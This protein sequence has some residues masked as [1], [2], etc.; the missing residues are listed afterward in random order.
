MV[1]RVMFY[2]SHE[3]LKTFKLRELT[4]QSDLT[5]PHNF[6]RSFI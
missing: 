4:V 5:Q 6:D 1:L 2:L 3:M